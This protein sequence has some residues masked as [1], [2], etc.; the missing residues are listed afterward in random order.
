MLTPPALDIVSPTGLIQS[1]KPEIK[2]LSRLAPAPRSRLSFLVDGRPVPASRHLDLSRLRPGQH[3]LGLCL[4]S[5]REPL[6]ETEFTLNPTLET[7]LELANRTPSPVRDAATRLT[8]AREKAVQGRTDLSREIIR[9][10]IA[11]YLARPQGS[12]ASSEPNLLLSH[13]RYYD[14]FC[15]RQYE[16]SLRDSALTP[17]RMVLEVGDT[18]IWR[19]TTDAPL[20]IASPDG[21][22][23]SATVA[24]GQSYRHTFRQPEQVGYQC[25]SK[26]GSH[27]GEILVQA[28]TTYMVEFPMLGPGRVPAV[29]DLDHQGNLWFTAGGGGFSKLGNVPLN[30]KIGCLTPQRTI[31]EYETP[32]LESAPTSIEVDGNGHVWFTERGGNNI[33]RLDP[34]TGTIQEYPI[35]TPHAGATGIEIDHRT[36]QVW[37]TEKKASK[38]GVLD[39]TTGR[40]VEYNT[41]NPESVPSTVA[42]DEEGMIWFDER[43]ADHLVR[44]NPA[45]GQMQTYTVPTPRSRV[46][47]IT[48]DKRGH[49]FFLELGGH[50]VG[51]LHIQSGLITEYAIPTKLATPFKLTIDQMSRVWFTQVF[52]NQIGVLNPDGRFVEFSIPTKDAMPGG[53]VIDRSGNVWFAEQAAN[54]IAMMPQAAL[55][56]QTQCH[57]PVAP[58]ASS[59]ANKLRNRP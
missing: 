44:L 21:T 23:Q 20:Q 14:L 12:S 8:L 30:N 13:L 42:I 53:I 36:G 37:F 11:D 48:P 45:T 33:G 39:P 50:K 16:V 49:V 58:V 43:G 46:V 5:E 56:S 54:R 25:M 19:N 22:F 38:L 55:F 51:K 17:D 47:G 9:S 15:E 3:V 41:P 52:G 29:M 26:N 24:P 18:L 31:R 10:L 34:A 32:T 28:R 27:R 6:V 7:L 35:P 2:F 57:L 59:I 40:I 4:E 1:L